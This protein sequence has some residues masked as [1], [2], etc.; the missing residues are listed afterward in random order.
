[1]KKDSCKRDS[2]EDVEFLIVEALQS[3]NQTL[4]A[5]ERLTL[6]AWRHSWEQDMAHQ[7]VETAKAT[8]KIAESDGILVCTI[9]EACTR[10]GLGRTR[11][12]EARESC[13]Q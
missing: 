5:F 3:A 6:A 11:V 13:G 1:M 4:K 10:T 7:T 8:P 2:R 9:K 12:Y